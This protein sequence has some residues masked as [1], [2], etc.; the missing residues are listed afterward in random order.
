MLILSLTSLAVNWRLSKHCISVLWH[1]QSE[2]FILGTCIQRY[3][4]QIQS[5]HVL[6]L[7]HA[8]IEP[9]TIAVTHVR[10]GLFLYNG[11]DH[12]MGAILLHKA[13]SIIVSRDGLADLCCTSLRPTKSSRQ[14]TIVPINMTHNLC[15]RVSCVCMMEMVFFG[16]GTQGNEWDNL[17]HYKS[18]RAKGLRTELKCKNDVKM[19]IGAI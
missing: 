9:P 18:Q 13:K 10:R 19:L 3:F 14:T 15:H 6:L 7:A 17:N 12:E 11:S 16:R 4:F 2:M 1:L 8:M 5:C